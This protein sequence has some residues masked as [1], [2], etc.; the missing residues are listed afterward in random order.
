[1]WWVLGVQEALQKKSLRSL[2]NTAV[3][4]ADGSYQESLRNMLECNGAGKIGA[5]K[6]ERSFV[7]E[8]C[9]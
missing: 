4:G 1:M 3:D 7:K 9:T 8:S 2:D 6:L 5:N